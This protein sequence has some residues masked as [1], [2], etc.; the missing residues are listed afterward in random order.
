VCNDAR[1]QEVYWACFERGLD[2]LMLPVG[3]EHV[4][5][6]ADVQLPD[7]WAAKSAS[8]AGRGF[9]AYTDLCASL[10]DR[11][12]RIDHDVLPGARE[13]AVLAVADLRVGRVHPP[14]SAVPVYVRNE[15]A[16]PKAP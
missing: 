11:L 8:G 1:M 12:T 7:G 2:G 16:R 14:E 13:I 5:K 6:P 3:T 9:A 10:S 4:T 15:V